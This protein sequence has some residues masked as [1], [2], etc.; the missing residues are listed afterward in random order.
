MDKNEL[1][2]KNYTNNSN[3]KAKK[4][5]GTPND[6]KSNLKNGV[7]PIKNILIVNNFVLVKEIGKGSFGE[8]YLTYNKRDNNQVATKKEIKTIE[9]DNKLKTEALIYQKLLNI[10]KQDLSGENAII[11][12]E[13]L[14]VPGFYGSGETPDFNYLIIDFLGPNLLDLLKICKGRKFT[15]STV[16]L[17]GLQII[18][19]IEY[20]HNHDF[21]HRDIKPENFL[22]GTQEKS[23]IIYLIDYGLS[24]RYRI[25]KNNQHIQYKE[26]KSLTGTARYVSINTHFGIEQSRRDDLESIGYILIFFLKGSLPWQGLK[27]MERFQNILEKKL[28]IPPELLCQGLPEEMTSYLNYCRSLHFE[29]RPDYDYLRGLFISILGKCIHV[30]GLL[31]SNMKFDW[32]YKDQD[33]IWQLFR[34]NS[35][36]TTINGLGESFNNIKINTSSQIETPMSSNII[37]SQNQLKKQKSRKELN[38]KEVIKHLS[39]IKE[40]EKEKEK[41]G[42]QSSCE[43]NH[44]SNSNKENSNQSNNQSEKDEKIIILSKSEDNGDDNNDEAKDDNSSGSQRTQKCSFNVDDIKIIPKATLLPQEEDEISYYISKILIK[45]STKSNSSSRD[46]ND[47][48]KKYSFKE[49]KSINLETNECHESFERPKTY[50]KAQTPTNAPRKTGNKIEIQLTR[51]KTIR[52]GSNCYLQS[53]LKPKANK[54]I[55]DHY[56]IKS[57]DNEALIS[58]NMSQVLINKQYKKEYALFTYAKENIIT[59][60]AKSA[61]CCGL[62]PIAEMI[63]DVKYCHFIIS[64]VSYN[65]ILR[66]FVELK[67]YTELQVK[68]V[69]KNLLN[70]INNIHHKKLFVKKLNYKDIIICN[71]SQIKIANYQICDHPYPKQQLKNSDL[72]MFTSPEYLDDNNCLIDENATTWK[73]GVILYLLLCGNIPFRGDKDCIL[74]NSLEFPYEEWKNISHEA[75]DLLQLMLK[76]SKRLSIAL[77]LRHAWLQ[78]DSNEEEPYMLS[79]TKLEGVYLVICIVN[80][81]KDYIQEKKDLE[82]DWS[83]LKLIEVN[84]CEDKDK[85]N[86]Q[87]LNDYYGDN[88][89]KALMTKH[90]EAVTIDKV[91]EIK[92]NEAK[93]KLLIRL[94][95]L[96]K[97]PT[98][99]IQSEDIIKQ[100]TNIDSSIVVS[101]IEDIELNSKGNNI[102]IDQCVKCILRKV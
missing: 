8:I 73:C 9:T 54:L 34:K 97:K 85:E 20:L 61:E 80:S 79:S 83:Q 7:K 96:L 70:V 29:D 90:E 41:R 43:H 87:I 39:T 31:K 2:E 98:V 11:Q 23:N 6:S 5:T 49:T 19:R 16:S 45:G 65:N 30:Y 101:I 22:I 10:K 55:W 100:L 46:H 86:K 84:D 4:T 78:D 14:G 72:I 59:S 52:G 102:T 75:I 1:K 91:I 37:S 47:I 42:T 35:R 74:R 66:H 77:C 82:N 88:D 67:Q 63:E 89:I 81:I 56:E 3:F 57:I 51:I 21:I 53:K 27:G 18:N 38:T 33:E 69:F 99:I 40:K 36:K 48:Q 28:Q 62:M 94:N 44:N 26:D 13:V 17:L 15:I 95:E 25:G 93:K 50:Y 60:L 32:C 58:S 64:N 76:H 24:K 68:C 12:D 71:N 92:Q